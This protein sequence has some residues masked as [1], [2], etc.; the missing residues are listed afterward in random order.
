MLATVVALYNTAGLTSLALQREDSRHGHRRSR[1]A[2]C[3]PQ[4]PIE[5]DDPTACV[6]GRGG[7][8]GVARR[9]PVRQT[10]GSQ[11]GSSS[12]KTTAH[13]QTTEVTGQAQGG[14]S[15]RARS[16]LGPKVEKIM[17]RPKYQY[18]QWG[19]LEV[20]PSDGRTV[21]SLGPADRF[22]S[23]FHSCCAGRW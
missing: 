5:E 7:C 10:R 17:N 18:G 23:A 2:C 12:S 4:G 19:Y 21:R 11:G 13:A 8:H 3:S 9:L 20:D 16:E 22:Y 14:G 1:T 6:D 15:G